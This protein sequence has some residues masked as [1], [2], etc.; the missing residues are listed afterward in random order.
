MVWTG[1]DGDL[2]LRGEEKP[3]ADRVLEVDGAPPG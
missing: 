2:G 3:E 1:Q